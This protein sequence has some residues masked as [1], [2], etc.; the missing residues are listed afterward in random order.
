MMSEFY[1]RFA[2]VAPAHKILLL[3]FSSDEARHAEIITQL[4][5]EASGAILS[6]QT[7]RA[8]EE[9]LTKAKEGERQLVRVVNSLRASGRVERE[10]LYQVMFANEECS[11]EFYRTLYSS[12]GPEERR[13]LLRILEEE[14]EHLEAARRLRSSIRER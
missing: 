2:E 7:P 3:R 1:R 9:A 4:I 11:V 5:E 8:V 6:Q 12:L 10:T 14:Y 13:M